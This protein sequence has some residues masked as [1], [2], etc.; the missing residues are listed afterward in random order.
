M[1]T[2]TEQQADVASERVGGRRIPGSRRGEDDLTPT[3]R[4]ARGRAARG[5]VPRSAHAA[6]EPSQHRR[7]PV[8]L[9]A[10]Q[11]RDRVP[12]LLPIRYGRMV[13]SPFAF[14]RGSAAVMA[15]DLPGTA[16]TGLRVQLCGDAHVSNFGGYASPERRMV[17][18]INDFDETLP[19]PW[20]WDVKR[21]AASLAI[22]GR[23]RGMNHAER[24]RVVGSAVRAYRE[25][26]HAFSRMSTLQVWYAHLTAEDAVRR[27]GQEA[28]KAVVRDA[29]SR[30]RQATSKDSS[31]AVR[32]L[33]ATVDGRR[34]IASDPP[35]LV[36]VDELAPADQVAALVPAVQASFQAYRRSLPEDRRRLLDRFAWVDMARK[37]VGVGSV[38]TRA[39]I[40][41]F[42]GQDESDP[43]MLQ[44]K[45]AK[46]SVLAPFAGASRYP[47]MG[48]RVVEGQRLMQASSDIFL[49]WSRGP[50]VDGAQRDF[51]VRQLWD[52]KLSTDIGRQTPGR[53]SI[54]GQICGWTLARA[55]ARSGDSIAIGSY[56]GRRPVFDDALAAFAE[57]YA[58]QN[59]RD[60]ARLVQAIRDGALPAVTGV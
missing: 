4:A 13:S 48:Q 51:Y 42:Q 41:L 56:L 5:S 8:E 26:V 53:L 9:L 28:G 11:G 39:W 54:I 60:H 16:S 40:V 30:A 52:W 44:I 34:R 21:L 33:T 2:K 57:A 36:P 15:A 1:T 35:L 46:E 27:W 45:E 24:R 31:L 7:D 14:F 18:D 29:L 50:V 6:W 49:G 43:L 23:E 22:A 47:N 37:V 3:E 59:E 19:G 25:A 17:F 55:H 12:E 58:D 32:K 20:E 38:G 10:E